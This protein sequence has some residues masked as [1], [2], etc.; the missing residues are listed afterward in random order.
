M[1]LVDD[2]IAENFKLSEFANTLDGGAVLLNP[3]VIV[4]V[5]MLQ[6]FRSWY[7]RP[8][9]ITSGYRTKEFNRRI[10]GASNSYHLVG[11]AADFLLPGE[12][13]GFTS[14]RRNE[15]LG[16]VRSKWETIC[17][18]HGKYSSVIYYDT[19]VHLSL[20]PTWRFEDRRV[21][22]IRGT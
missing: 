17:F 13:A 12:F 11:L 9:R 10:G 20:W 14:V 6:E 15:F 19:F 1:K 4:F 7:R 16:N 18:E 8:M 21:R 3:D 22:G 2:R 5:Q